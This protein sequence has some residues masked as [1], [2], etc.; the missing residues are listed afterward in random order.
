M[1]AFAGIVRFDGA[2]IG[3]ELEDRLVRA[4]TILRKGRT[5]T[6]RSPGAA[7]VQRVD[8]PID[9]ASAAPI[10]GP[11]APLFVSLCHLDNR[12]ELGA[13]LGI[14]APELARLPDTALLMRMVDKEGDEEVARCLG[15][16]V[17]ASWDVNRRA[18]T[19]G[20]DCL[21]LSHTLFF[22]RDGNVA[23]FATTL[24]G[25]LSLPFVPREIDEISLADYVAVNVLET[26]RTFYRGIERVPTRTMVTLSRAGARHRYYWSPDL[27]APPPYRRDEDYIERARELFDQAVAAATDGQQGFAVTLSG[28]LD[29]SAVAATAVRLGRGER[30]ACYTLVPPPG[31]VSDPRARAYQDETDKVQALSRLYPQLDVHLLM[32][33]APHPLEEDTTRHFAETGL[34]VNSGPNFGWFAYLH[35]AVAA[36][37][38]KVLATGIHGNVGLTWP[39]LDF[40][41]TLLSTGEWRRFA[42]ELKVVAAEY[43]QSLSHIFLSR[44]VLANMPA[45]VH[46]AIH[47]LRGRD[48]YNVAGFSPLNPAFIAE[49]DLPRHWRE[50]G[51]DPWFRRSRSTL[52]RHRA[53]QVFDHNLPGRDL[54]SLLDEQYGFQL[55]DPHADRRLLEFALSVPETVYRRDGV[56]RWFARQVFADRLP[57]EILDERRRGAQGG[58]WFQRLDVRRQE[59]AAE[60]ERLEASPLASRMLDVPRLK[61]LVDDW[62]KDDDEALKRHVDYKS[63]FYRGVHF[64][65]FIRWVEGGNA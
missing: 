53:A 51:F 29:S 41:W 15:G 24:V 16:F 45:S 64:G 8:S 43:D 46:R 52:R 59:I 14:P 17:F 31:C 10:A 12:P 22:Y 48:P 42:R 40:L 63:V 60:V 49:C 39:G 37:G 6:R 33:R 7:F 26:R 23:A 38:H 4:V 57:R 25:L 55:R 1:A 5:Q 65:R 56:S 35:D 18:L 44:I 19:L 11:E 27:N 50:V 9:A 47:R 32:P 13:A 36:G 62:P 30:V 28:G 58:A 34:P 3:A 54:I 20:R 21:G 61:Q 2:P